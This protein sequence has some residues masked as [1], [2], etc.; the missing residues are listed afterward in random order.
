M[1]SKQICRHLPENIRPQAITLCEAIFVMQK[2]IEEFAPLM[3][4]E[5]LYQTV[6]LGT[7]ETTKRPNPAIQEYRNLV[8]DYA[9]AIKSLNDILGENA[10]A[11]EVSSLQ[12]LKNKYKVG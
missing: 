12:S 8:R 9:G 11:P 3:V 4:G 2:K 5:E 10:S 1:T 6:I 7:G